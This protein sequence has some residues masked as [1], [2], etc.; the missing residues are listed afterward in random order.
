MQA[1]T[2]QIIQ[3]TAGGVLNFEFGFKIEDATWSRDPR[4]WVANGL[5]MKD[6]G[7][8]IIGKHNETLVHP[9]HRRWGPQ[10]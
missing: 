10:F 7:S 3:N 2:S 4:K 6:M 5:G 1:W 9:K 8:S